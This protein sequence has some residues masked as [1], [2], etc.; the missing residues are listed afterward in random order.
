ML[1]IYTE[2]YKHS[3]HTVEE[4]TICRSGEKKGKLGHGMAGS[5]GLSLREDVR[6]TRKQGKKQRKGCF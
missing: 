5:D 3:Q 1:Y 4:L 2:L 6:T